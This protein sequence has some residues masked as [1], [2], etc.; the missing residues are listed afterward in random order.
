[1]LARNHICLLQSQYFK[2]LQEQHM[3]T[4]LRGDNI[5][6]L[7][8]IPDMFAR[9]NSMMYD[10]ACESYKLFVSKGFCSPDIFQTNYMQLAIYGVTLSNYFIGFNLETEEAD[11]YTSSYYL[12]TQLATRG[13][14]MGKRTAIATEMAT[15]E[16]VLVSGNRIARS[17]KEGDR[18]Q[19]V[20][21]DYEYTNGKLIF[22]PTVPRSQLDFKRYCF[23][24][25][26]AVQQAM[27]TL[28]EQ[29]QDKVL[30]VTMGDK[31][32]YITKSFP[33]LSMV[34]GEQRAKH[35]IT[36]TFDSRTFRF[37][38]PSVGAS[39]YS[40]GVTN[41]NLALVDRIRVATL[42]D[43]DLSEVKL[44]T[45]RAVDYIKDKIPNLNEQ[46]LREVAEYLGISIRSYSG[47]DC[48]QIF[49]NGLAMVSNHRAYGAIKEFPQYFNMAEFKGY[50]PR[51]SSGEQVDIPQTMQELDELFKTGIFRVMLRTKKGSMTSIVCTNSSKCLAQI[52]G[53]DY[54][55]K[56]ESAGNKLR[57]LDYIVKTKY[58]DGIDTD[59][60]N[61]LIKSY[62][63][64]GEV[65]EIFELVD[66]YDTVTYDMVHKAIARE[67][68][69]I[70][71]RTTVIKQTDLITVRNCECDVD[72]PVPA[73]FY[74]SINPRAITG[75][76]RLSRNQL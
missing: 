67:L 18:I 28:N 6:V 34:Y 19:A 1:M 69:L 56:F 11:L 15:I 10:F 76:V 23:V 41:I 73:T 37:L 21:L 74:K 24:A 12:L 48:L 4:G 68:Y 43:I 36:A 63:L 57:R 59:T 60:L 13:L 70:Q 20:R 52:Y 42:S 61:N 71:E 25:L 55:A 75:I 46:A 44:D 39:I 72:N 14:L 53:S 8:S 49:K 32:R 40:S 62:N 66:D 54:Y 38:A 2:Q 50:A 5:S 35:L 9:N 16:E 31:I 7:L 27:T 47:L 58:A 33:I 65:Q 64:V 26:P 45:S 3:Q 22:K 29:I 51:Y 30:E 17:L